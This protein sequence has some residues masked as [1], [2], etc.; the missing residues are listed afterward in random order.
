MAGAGFGCCMALMAAWKDS[1]AGHPL[2]PCAKGCAI[3]IE[4]ICR[5]LING[6]R[7]YQFGLFGRR[8]RRRNRR[9]GRSQKAGNDSQAFHEYL[10]VER[11]T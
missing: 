9:Y 2:E 4:Q 8:S 5:E 10:L 1:A 7:H 3:F 11:L 6:N